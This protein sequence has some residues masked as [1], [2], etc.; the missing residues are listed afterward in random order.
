MEDILYSEANINSQVSFWE[1][2]FL[3]MDKIKML[4]GRHSAWPVDL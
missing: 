4:N 3:E 1:L 2:Y